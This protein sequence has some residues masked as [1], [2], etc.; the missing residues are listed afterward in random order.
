MNFWWKTKY[1]DSVAFIPRCGSTSLGNLLMEQNGMPYD[2][3]L[4]HLDTGTRNKYEMKIHPI[5]ALQENNDYA[6]Y[7]FCGNL[8][9]RNP[10]DRFISGLANIQFNDL[11]YYLDSLSEKSPKN[12]NV[13]IRPYRFWVD[14]CI[15]VNLFSFEKDKNI[16][17]EH[18][19]LG[20]FPHKN[21]TEGNKKV[22]VTKKQLKKI[23]KIC[24]DDL[25]IYKSANYAGTPCF[26]GTTS[27]FLDDF[28]EFLAKIRFP[29]TS[30]KDI[31]NLPADINQLLRSHLETFV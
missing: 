4:S 23:E 17:C 13:H 20:K 18:L 28:N 24:V 7:R 15:M 25:K 21:K 27:R 1:G 19:K 14:S 6:R 2:Q 5:A 16:F 31:H 22:D 8:L 30:L 9:L 10:V 3:F 12:W 26:T 11:D 29:K